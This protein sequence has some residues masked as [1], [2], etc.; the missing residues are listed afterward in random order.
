MVLA[1]LCNE[2]GNCMTFCPEDGDPAQVKPKLFLTQERFDLAQGQ[3]FLITADNGGLS[4]MAKP[5]SESEAERLHSV[6]SN[7]EGIPVSVHG[8]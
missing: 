4:V 7:E 8:G 2:C 3:G 1:E 6:I 5:E